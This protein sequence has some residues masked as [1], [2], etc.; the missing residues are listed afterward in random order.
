MASFSRQSTAHA[1]GH[2]LLHPNIQ[3]LRY[4]PTSLTAESEKFK[5]RGEDVGLWDYSS[6]STPLRLLAG[7]G[8]FGAGVAYTSFFTARATETRTTQ[9]LLA[10][11]YVVFLFC[12]AT[13]LLAE[14]AV[15]VAVRKNPDR[16]SASYG[17]L[18]IRLAIFVCYTCI[19]AGTTL[20]TLCLVFTMPHAIF[21]IGC[22]GLLSSVIV[23][24]LSF[25]VLKGDVL[26]PILEL[27]Q[28]VHDGKALEGRKL[29]RRM[30]TVSE[31]AHLPPSFVPTEKEFSTFLSH[32]RRYRPALRVLETH[33]ETFRWATPLRLR[34]KRLAHA[35]QAL[36]V[37]SITSL[38]ER[39]SQSEQFLNEPMFRWGRSWIS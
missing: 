35:A 39:A 15:T 34:A 32:Y 33:D 28:W 5:I 13:T 30:P 16:T 7:V 25:W 10:A 22:V 3:P 29:R 20:L 24:V 38:H 4:S 27:Y 23:V 6:S 9:S 1:L 26:R 37:D 36:K 19:L 21:A 2:Q 18:S 14:L 12:V 17:R 8:S 31:T 11:S